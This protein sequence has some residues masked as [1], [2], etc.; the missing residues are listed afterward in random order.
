LNRVFS[1]AI[2]ALLLAAPRPVAAADKHEAFERCLVLQ[3][4]DIAIGKMTIYLGEKHLRVDGMNGRC[5]FVSAAPRWDVI[6]YNKDKQFC[7]V[8][9][10]DWRQKGLKGIE[11]S[12]RAAFDFRHH[13]P[14]PTTYMGKAAYS[15]KC[16]AAPPSGGCLELMYQPGHRIKL[17]DNR[18]GTRT[19][20]AS[21]DFVIN[22]AAAAF[23]EGFYL[24]APEARIMLFA[25][26]DYNQH[27]SREFE[28]L[29]IGYQN[30]PLSS[31][32]IP[33]GLKPAHSIM[34]VATG[35]DMESIMLDSAEIKH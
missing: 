33:A 5:T 18:P 21:S 9:G 7:L 3:Q 31:F 14:R 32:D 27:K 4:R 34:A 15:V 28:T 17:P 8:S 1:I 10:K 26:L 25:E 16:V 13:L 12:H 2:A 35:S 30:V 23:V 20:I 11:L 29:S 24:T 19:L 22:E 6:V